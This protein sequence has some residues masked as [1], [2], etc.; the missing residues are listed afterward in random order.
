MGEHERGRIS[1]I[2]AV[3][4]LGTRPIAS[5]IDG[6]LAQLIGARFAATVILLPTAVVAALVISKARAYDQ[7]RS[8]APVFDV[9]NTVSASPAEPEEGVGG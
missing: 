3:C 8:A 6:A 7:L 4:F 2:W 5:L 9:T 1:A